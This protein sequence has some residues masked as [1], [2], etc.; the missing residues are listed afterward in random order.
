V[1]MWSARAAATLAACAGRR[2]K[3]GLEKVM[4]P[5]DRPDVDAAAD[6]S[7]GQAA[8]HRISV[9]PRAAPA[10]A[11]AGIFA[12]S[13]QPYDLERRSNLDRCCF[14]GDIVR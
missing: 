1:P 8:H 4:P 10:S 3:P 6:K 2:H 13:P 14:T 11:G 9:S 5:V 12:P 7:V